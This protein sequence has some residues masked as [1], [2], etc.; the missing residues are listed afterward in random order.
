MD[1]RGQFTFY[2]SIF[3]S[4]SRIRSKAARAD[5]YDA[6]CNYALNGIEP[7]LEKL[8][9]TAAVGFISAKPNLDASKRK[10]KSGRKGGKSKRTGSKPEANEKQTPSEKENENEKEN[11]IEIEGEKDKEQTGSKAE[12]ASPGSA[13]P[14]PKAPTGY[15]GQSFS[16][17]W[18]AYPDGPSKI[19]REAAYSAWRSLAP[20]RQTAKA[21]LSALEAWKKSNRWL[22]DNGEYVPSAAN[23]LAKGYWKSPPVPA[24]PKGIP[25]GASGVLGEAELEAIQKVLREEVPEC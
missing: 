11:E 12:A 2:A 6:I 3:Y 9:D 15:D 4:A 17:F 10:A 23:F 13:P 21:I 25:M 20:S 5:F 7:C 22:D 18:N 8:T 1:E 16:V 19:D 14:A 24:Q